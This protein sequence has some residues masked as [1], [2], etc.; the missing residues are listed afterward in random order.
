MLK[1]NHNGSYDY[2]PNK[3]VVPSKEMNPGFLTTRQKL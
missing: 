1:V 3:A 2:Q